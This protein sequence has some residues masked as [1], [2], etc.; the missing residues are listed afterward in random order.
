MSLSD[1]TIVSANFAAG[2]FARVSKR[3]LAVSDLPNMQA[4]ANAVL[5]P[6]RRTFGPVYLTSYIRP[7]DIGRA[8]EN[9]RAI[10]F[11]MSDAATLEAAFQWAATFLSGQFG[12]IIH[13]RDHVHVTLPGPEAWAG[14]GVVL[15]EPREGEY[16]FASIAP[17][18]VAG[19]LAGQSFVSGTANA[20][21][22]VLPMVTNPDPEQ[23]GIALALAF[24]G[25][26]VVA[27][28]AKR[29]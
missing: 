6:I 4:L 11:V 8:H 2:E 19:T 13:E 7:A 14:R 24:V 25:L 23:T 22:T 28:V 20:S 12:R 29:S 3:P 26:L 5:Q 15:R 21:A 27:L 1:L 10:D 16:T 9:G 17:I 18:V